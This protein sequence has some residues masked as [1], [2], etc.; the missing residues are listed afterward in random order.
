MRFSDQF[1]G[2]AAMISVVSD[3]SKQKKL[4]DQIKRMNEVRSLYNSI[5]LHKFRMLPRNYKKNEQILK[6]FNDTI[7][8]MTG[9]DQQD[10]HSLENKN[11]DELTKFLAKVAG[12]TKEN[13]TASQM[14]N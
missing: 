3:K 13:R 8:D 7:L 14:S 9:A 5:V 6:L 11:K 1:T 4:W 12:F 2:W 10:I